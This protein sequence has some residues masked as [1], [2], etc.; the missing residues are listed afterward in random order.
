MLFER[1][2]LM[3]PQINHTC[4]PRKNR[5]DFPGALN[6]VIARGI[7]K[8]SIFETAEDKMFFLQR[9]NKL[10]EENDFVLYAW[11]IMENH[12]H[13]LIQ[14]G[15]V[16]LS[17]IMRKLLTGYAVN[18][19][20]KY[21]RAGHLFQNRYKSI[22]CEKDEYLLRLVRYIHLNPVKANI[23]Q[24]RKLDTYFWTSH[25]ELIQS[26][27]KCLIE[28]DE[29]F[30]YFGNK[31]SK[32]LKQYRQFIHDGVNLNEKLDG[33]GLQKSVG[34]TLNEIRKNDIQMFDD[35]VLGTGDFVK[36]TLVNQQQ[37]EVNV[38][39]SVEELMKLLEVYFEID[40]GDLVVRS[41]KTKNARDVFIFT[42]KRYLR[43]SLTELGE[44]I[45][46]K[47][48]AASIAFQRGNSICKTLNLE[49]LLKVTPEN[50]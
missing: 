48:A 35:R 12:F 32:A 49:K 20:R 37:A 31:R 33:G 9:M 14:T 6:H 40:K 25:H 23:V 30:S 17:T 10:V 46:I 8:K 41:K 13:L 28:R 26:S 5:I 7:D 39:L 4:M 36:K 24:I 34:K 29:I 44:R 42:G 22:L 15:E 2:I 3:K 21:K 1:L 47:R 19:N 11:C 50:L 45:G 27:E 18:Y 16:P 38:Q 43:K